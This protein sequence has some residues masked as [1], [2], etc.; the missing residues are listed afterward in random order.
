MDYLAVSHTKRTRVKLWEGV[1]L[2]GC[3]SP[4]QAAPPP[5]PLQ[6]NAGSLRCKTS[7]KEEWREL[8]CYAEGDVLLK[9]ILDDQ[10]QL[11]KLGG[12]W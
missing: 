9:C 3:D 5:P 10:S 11:G 12:K 4:E 1:I 8:I 2:P 7:G 6:Q